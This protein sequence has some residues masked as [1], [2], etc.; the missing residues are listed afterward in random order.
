M[1]AEGQKRHLR[2]VRLWRAKR[3]FDEAARSTTGHAVRSIGGDVIRPAEQWEYQDRR[4]RSRPHVRELEAAPDCEPSPAGWTETARTEARRDRQ[5][6]RMELHEGHVGCAMCLVAGVTDRRVRNLA[7]RRVALEREEAPA[8]LAQA[9]PATA[10]GRS[11]PPGQLVISSM[12]AMVTPV[13]IRHATVGAVS[14]AGAAP[15]DGA[16]PRL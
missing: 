13:A 15:A 2:K 9:N 11:D 10:P 4:H 8:A 7:R 14:P 3:T 1:S 12:N 5:Q 16:T 6:Y